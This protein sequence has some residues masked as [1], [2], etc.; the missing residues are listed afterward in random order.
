CARE[1]KKKADR[2]TQDRAL[3]SLS[4]LLIADPPPGSRS[5][6]IIHPLDVF[7]GFCIYH[8]F[9]ALFYEN[10]AFDLETGLR[11]YDLRCAGYR[12]ALD[13]FRRLGN[14]KDELGREDKVDGLRFPVDEFVAIAFP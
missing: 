1:Q 5:G 14:D 7:T 10:W 6:L 8:D 2:L 13:R 4:W 9:L 12:V 3:K 11:G